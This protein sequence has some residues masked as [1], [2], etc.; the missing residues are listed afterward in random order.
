M[1]IYAAP[2]NRRPPLRTPNILDTLPV[3]LAVVSLVTFALVGAGGLDIA[4]LAI[5]GGEGLL[6]LALV[7]G[8]G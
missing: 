4:W 6:A 5:A 8:R 2:P 1:G 7:I 3:A